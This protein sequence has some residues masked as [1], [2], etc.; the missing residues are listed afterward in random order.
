MK[1]HSFF[2]KRA[3]KVVLIGG[4]AL[5]AAAL[6]VLAA[7]LVIGGFRAARQADA[8]VSSFSSFSSGGAPEAPSDPSDGSEPAPVEIGLSVSSPKSSAVTVTS[9]SFTFTGTCDPAYPLLLNGAELEKDASGAFSHTVALEIGA[10][11]FVLEHK[12]E[13]RSYTV[14][15][16]YIVMRACDPSNA[17]SFDSGVSF[18][19]TVS[20][21][22][23]AVCSATFNGVTIPLER[24]ISQEELTNPISP[25]EFRDFVGIFTL[26]TGNT[27]ALNLGKITFTATYNGITDTMTSGKITCKKPTVPVI[28]EVT[29]FAA[30][31]FNGNSTDNATRP[32]NNYLPQGTVDYVNGSF[33]AKDGKY[34][35]NF[36]ILR[37]GRRIYSD[38]PITPGNS[39][40][41][42]A[43][44]YEGTLP[45]HNELSVASLTQDARRTYLTLNTLWKAPFFLDL[46][47]QSYT[48][49]AKQDYTV[50]AVTMQYVEIEF[51]YA[52]VFSGSVDIPADHP[53]FSSAQVIPGNGTTVLRL[54]LKKAGA[55]YGWDC[56][57][58]AAGQL[59]FEF[60]HPPVSTASDANEYGIDLTGL[61]IVVDAG[62]GGIDPGAAGN[63]MKEAERNLQLAFKIKTEL[64]KTGATVLMTRTSDA[65]LQSPARVAL[66]RSLKPD[67]LVSVHHDSSTAASANGFGSYYTTPFSHNAAQAVYEETMATGLYAAGN[68][69]KLAWHFFYMTRMTFCPAV[70]TENGFMGGSIDGASIASDAANTQKAQAIVR[71][72]VRYFASVQ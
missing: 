6:A 20:A 1:L 17:R 27:T 9:P 12:G 33:S 50:S 16:R 28:A 15:Y 26:P 42:V 18:A 51:C 32:T 25:E 66:Y 48:N 56:S 63:G 55:F 44:T 54:H 70:L 3:G 36:L 2:Q 13:T 34:T 46:K 38:M 45:D 24:P 40:V 68:H 65:T 39:R 21:R 22:A 69:N 11:S 4:G 14:T 7:V 72:I 8:A 67:F 35:N 43:K 62:H 60:L 10:N 52:T 53:L 61:R 47:P 64:E 49:P 29:A 31:T 37:C 5:L 41:Q 71:G 59:V 58:N 19:A 57:Y 23:G 30:E